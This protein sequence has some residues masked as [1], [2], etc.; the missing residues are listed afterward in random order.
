MSLLA[1][2]PHSPTLA[3]IA[4]LAG[5]PPLPVPSAPSVPLA[6][7][8]PLLVHL[9]AFHVMQEPLPL[10]RALPTPTP[11][12]LVEPGLIRAPALL[13]A[14]RA[15]MVSTN[16]PPVRPHAQAVLLAKKASM[17]L[18]MVS[19]RVLRLPAPPAPWAPT[20]LIR[21]VHR[22]RRALMAS[23][24]DRPVNHRVL[25]A[26]LVRRASTVLATVNASVL[27]WLALTVLQARTVVWVLH[28]ALAVLMASSKQT[29]AK[30]RVLIALQVRRA[31]TVSP[32]DSVLLPQALA[33]YAHLDPGR[34]PERRPAP[35]VPLALPTLRLVALRLAVPV[36]PAVSQTQLVPRTALR[37]QKDPG[38]LWA[39]R[40][41][42]TFV[43]QAKRVRTISRL[44]RPRCCAWERVFASTVPLEP[45]RLREMP[46]ARRATLAPTMALP[47]KQRALTAHLELQ[48]PT[49][50][51]LL[52][53]R[54][55]PART[56]HQPARP[57][58]SRA[59]K[60]STKR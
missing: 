26:L 17:V 7:I 14:L 54:A 31:S 23:I 4:S 41:P 22:A 9:R 34:V 25:A 19:A 18:D 39:V 59:P 29:L 13:L 55:L 2:E 52:A 28:S 51:K 24:R 36:D 42:A 38:N 57:R 47:L 5:I 46:T 60:A 16:L 32:M 30:P 11:A 20:V 56:S 12:S 8:V 44:Q 10:S 35:F 48:T 53:P 43:P 45:I 50:A 3:S 58:A 1:A 21:V 37:A 33:Q 49:R 6:S 40:H 27:P 15:R